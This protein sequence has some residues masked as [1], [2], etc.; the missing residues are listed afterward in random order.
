[1]GVADA[2]RSGVD[3]LPNARERGVVGA[4]ARAAGQDGPSDEVRAGARQR[5]VVGERRDRD[6]RAPGIRDRERISDR[7]PDGYLCLGG[8]LRE[9]TGTPPSTVTCADT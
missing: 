3:C 2:D 1:L 8:G 4:L 6:G 7:R 5:P 9:L